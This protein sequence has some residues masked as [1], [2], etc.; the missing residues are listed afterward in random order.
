MEQA[1][2]RPRITDEQDQAL[3]GGGVLVAP[4]PRTIFTRDKVT[5][6]QKAFAD[7]ADTFFRNAI[8]TK[9]PAI[10]E[11]AEVD[12]PDGK[13]VPL[14]I[15]LVRQA[16]DV[17]LCSIEIPEKFG[18]LGLDLTTAM[19]VAEM[20]RGCASFAATLGAHNGIGT[21]PI[22]YFG[23]E[24]QKQEWLPRLAKA[25]K[26]ACYAL[27][28]PGNGSDALGGKTTATLS[29]DKTHFVL[30]GQKQF[31]TNGAWADVAVVF[32]QVGGKYS[33]LIVDLHTPG[34]V[35]GAE[36]KKMG[37]RGSSTTQLIFQDVKV[38]VGNLLG[39]P[40]DAA[41]IALNIL[42]VGRMKLGFATLGT[43]KY[44][45]DLTVAY[46]KSRKQFGRPIIQFDLQQRKLAEMAAW[47]YACDALC[48]RIVGQ[49]DAEVRRLPDPHDPAG[50]VEVLRRYGLECAAI[51][52]HG[53]ESLSRVLYHALRMHGGYG[54]C[55]EYQVERLTRDNVVETIYEGTNDINRIVLSGALAESVH[56]SAIPFR[57]FV[58]E[59]ARA[60]RDGDLEVGAAEGWLGTEVQRVWA[61]KRA[62]AW[63]VEH[64]FIGVGQ[65]LKVE[66]QVL[67]DLGDALLAVMAAEAALGRTLTLGEHDGQAGPRADATRLSIAEAHD[68]VARQ[69]REALGHAVA[70][71]AR[72]A[73]L[74]DLER[75]LGAVPA[76]EDLVEVRRRLAT[77]VARKGAYTL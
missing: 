74:A 61:L 54:F 27:T 49:V 26:I 15:D 51:K 30:N 44:V 71:A 62:L 37:I 55:E 7:A 58:D 23:N 75:L 77:H 72:A 42:Y 17:G 10:E 24:A 53:S 22:A 18:G 6:E 29:A 20:L 13:K 34:V 11:K 21:L 9:I 1:L 4:V 19:H 31:I 56:G 43:T 28:E 63:A 69:T 45:I 52:I 39:E 33:G 64:A 67:I 16:A 48:Y 3:A 12:G 38:P 8:W 2:A 73:R 35:R 66:Q 14:V 41:K 47:A 70:P 76:G 65:D 60:L 36:E 25:E 46:M 40:G 57:E 50:L 32:A 68:E 59:T 5:D